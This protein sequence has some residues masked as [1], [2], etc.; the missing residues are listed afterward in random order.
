[1]KIGTRLRTTPAS[2]CTWSGTVISML[3]GDGCETDET[4]DPSELVVALDGGGVLVVHNLDPG[5][6]KPAR[7]H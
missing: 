4:E 2:D 6:I 7:L 5:E 3:D 1:M